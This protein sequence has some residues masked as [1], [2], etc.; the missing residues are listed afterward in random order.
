M[1]ETR[2]VHAGLFV[3][4]C[5]LPSWALSSLCHKL[6]VDSIV[7]PP[8]YFLTLS[9]FI[10]QIL[11]SLFCFY[12]LFIRFLAL[13]IQPSS[14]AGFLSGFAWQTLAK[15]AF[16]VSGRCK[17]TFLLMLLQPSKDGLCWQEQWQWRNDA[18]PW[19]RAVLHCSHHVSEGM[20]LRRYHSLYVIQNSVEV[21]VCS[22]S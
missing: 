2:T 15:L 10:S 16:P 13:T 19:H 18:C 7:V 11:F 20:S 12:F 4:F 3:D 6:K 1:L 8:L 17:T 22:L 5:G 14:V 9:P 21:N